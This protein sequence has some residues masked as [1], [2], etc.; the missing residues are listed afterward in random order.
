MKQARSILVAILSCWLGASTAA[1]PIAAGTGKQTADANG[2]SFTV[3]TYIACCWLR[4]CSQ[5][6]RFRFGVTSKAAS[7]R[8]G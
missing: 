3:F 2:T 7:S 5:S 8:T 1:E 6:R 4:R